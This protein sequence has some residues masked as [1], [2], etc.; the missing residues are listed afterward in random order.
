MVDKK[1]LESQIFQRRVIDNRQVSMTDTVKF[2]IS[3]DSTQTLRLAV[4]YF[5]ISGLLL[6]KD[7]FTKFMMEHN[8]S[9]QV[10]MGNQ[11]NQE[12]V[13]VL[14]AKSSK[15]YLEELPSLM[16]DDIDGILEEEDFLKLVRQW[17][18][19]G[20]IEVKVYTGEANYFHAKSYLFSQSFSSS[21]GKAVVGSSNFSK[22]G[23]EGNTELNVFGQDNY[24]ALNDWYSEL[25]ES[26]E[27]ESFS[28]ELIEIVKGK[29]PNWQTGE[30]YKTVQET[31]YDFAQIYGKPYA[32]LDENSDWIEH[33][34]PHQRIGVIDIWDKLNTYG[35]AILADGV[36]LGKTRTTAGI[37]KTSLDKNPGLRTLIIA[38]NKLK[39]QWTEEL[40]ILGIDS[41]KFQYLSRE[42]FALS[43]GKELEQMAQLFDLVIVDEAHL[44]FKN[45]GTRAY[46]NLQIVDQ[47]AISLGKKIK[48]LM[49]TATPWN[50]SRKDVL[51]LGSLFLDI[52]SIPSNRHYQQYF[53][54]GNN[55]RVINKLVSDDVA[56]NEFW[57]DLFLQRTRKT[58]G[59]QNVSFAQR[60]FPTV[61][62]PYEPRKNRIFVDNFERISN[63]KF[64]Y[65]DAIRYINPERNDMSGD[66]L[67][68]MLLKRADSSWRSYLVSLEGIKEK[69][70]VLLE[71][72]DRVKNSSNPTSEF[73]MMLSRRYN[74]DDYLSKQIGL[75]TADVSLEDFE[76]E[77]LLSQYQLD[78]KIKKRRYFE[79]IS[80]QIDSIKPNTAKAT[81]KQMYADAIQD[82]EVL[83]QLITELKEAY[84]LV[85]EK[86]TKVEE[87]IVK[88]L[89]Q[90]RK[91]ILI[92]QFADTA[93]Y[94]YENLLSSNNILSDNLGL[95]T[96]NDEDNRIGEY[97]ETKK[98]ILDRFS[99]LSKN[100]KD[101]FGTVKEINLLVG[102]D[103]ISTG[104]NLQDAVVLM[105]LDLPYNPM[106]LEQRIGR[107]DRPRQD[108]SVNNI[109]VYTFPV[110]EAIDVELQM[111]ERL[112]KKMAGVMS[113]T[114]FDDI[115]LPEYTSYLE[116]VKRD[117]G[118]A[119]QTMLDRT[120]EK[121]I[122][123]QGTVSEKHS[124]DY[125]E[126]NKRLYDTKNSAIK[127]TEKPVYP[128]Y[129]FSKNNSSHTIVVARI[130]Y[131]DA[132]GA[133][134]S[135]EERIFDTS[136]LS[137][138]DI[139]NAESHL[140]QS[141][142]GGISSTAELSKEK[143][144]ILLGNE[145]EKLEK[146]K[147][148]L[149]DNFN[150]S[151]DTAK[152]NLQSL[153]NKTAEKA[154]LEIGNSV[155]D[156]KNRSLI[157]SKLQ[158]AGLVPK[159]VSKIANVIRMVDEESELFQYV[160]EIAA[161]VDRFWLDFTDY[162]E[163]FDFSRLENSVGAKVKRASNRKANIEKTEIEVIIGNIVFS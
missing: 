154:A 144:E 155:K 109:F 29:F 73:K 106:V 62:I 87:N 159:D 44:G 52:D 60:Q 133:A 26:D 24:F 22:N 136:E 39:V 66:R 61:E 85:D 108:S 123:N 37:V 54:F 32:E 149:V 3:E 28:A 7:E 140:R 132:N 118:K 65:M 75:L 35:T 67:K 63:L 162:A 130:N 51:N 126:A 127:R 152:S 95:I 40:A 163:L 5:Y 38:D 50:N 114:E 25:W 17:I 82:D 78:S 99:P 153:Q 10:M 111:S 156:I 103:T 46:R 83:E 8:G 14:S 13:D 27:V 36:G 90:G 122:Y 139:T 77:T 31:Y 19:E 96:G 71:D 125:K 116:D 97:P 76:D 45:R 101:I 11:T 157:M 145:L 91:V 161:N 59:G 55:Q 53:L 138:S 2:L 21:Q 128:K 68:L 121:T 4:G 119:V 86:F 143:S 23:L 112:G 47:H 79:K 43:N 34:Y 48:G 89:E 147:Q 49:L 131:K 158:E 9:V 94:Y 41:S 141:K 129:S 18:N 20:R 88:E 72:L 12:T 33:L 124:T 151:V 113:D 70:R 150:Q 6:I 105:N 80:N 42:K 120:V 57:E 137:N 15:E 135:T 74:L 117:K 115:V 56:F 102:T 84:S 58:Y 146:Y 160:K 1:E 98:E 110:Y 64:P 92:S 107:I 81:I 142:I 100:R 30:P 134:I 148:K 93:K 69:N 104:Q 16:S